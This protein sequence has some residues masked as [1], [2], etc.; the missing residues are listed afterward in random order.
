M[1][2][3]EVL[4]LMKATDREQARAAEK[5]RRYKAEC[6]TIDRIVD[7]LRGG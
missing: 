5:W 4:R 3:R 2:S 1:T 7:Q 6:A